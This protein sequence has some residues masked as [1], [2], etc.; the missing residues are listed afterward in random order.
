MAG[1]YTLIGNALTSLVKAPGEIINLDEEGIGSGTTTYKAHEDSIVALA[2]NLEEH[3]THRWLKKKTA[4]IK[5][6]EGG[7]GLLTVNWEG[8]P[9]DNP[10]SGP[11]GD[12]K[13]SYSLR[14]VARTQPIETHPDFD[15][16][17]GSPGAEANNA[18]FN[19]DGKFTGFGVGN[20]ELAGVRSFLA[21]SVIY[22]EVVTMNSVVAEDIGIALDAIGKTED[23]PDSKIKPEIGGDYNWLRIGANAQEVGDGVKLTN[24]WQLSGPNGW[25]T[26]IY[27]A[28]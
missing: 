9:D 5:F 6:E 21:P 8:I 3:E 11:D 18:T 22:Q 17:A 25:S 27:P 28:A 19:E 16:F 12:Y 10:G 4:R 20:D 7:M 13:K 14:S 1:D 26:L 24:Q 23:P 15:T 2:T